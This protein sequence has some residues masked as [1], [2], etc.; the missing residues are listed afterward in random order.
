MDNFNN[1]TVGDSQNSTAQGTNDMNSNTSTQSPAIP[2][3]D[4]ILASLTGM[5]APEVSNAPVGMQE[6][7]VSSSPVLEQVTPTIPTFDTTPVQ[8][9]TPAVEEIPS[10]V[11]D[12]PSFG[13]NTVEPTP[14]IENVP[15]P[16]QESVTPVESTPMDTPVVVDNNMPTQD[17]SSV[18]GASVEVTAPV[19][20]PTVEQ[21]P[22]PESLPSISP[23]EQKAFGLTESSNE[24][25]TD[26][27][28]PSN[29]SQ[30]L[31]SFTPATSAEATLPES[32][33]QEVVS[34]LDEKKDEKD[35][36]GGTAVV[37]VLIIIIVGLLATIGFFAYKIFF[38]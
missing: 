17:S 4:D 7:P 21:S 1:N 33:A 14:V 24:S 11:Q 2:T 25:T 28:S 35:G 37:V 27:S 18:F 19:E 16:V 32:P 23:E 10:L 6:T 26:T 12:L 15:T 29:L 9:S 5:P 38:Q 20:T 34:T 30:P 3:G 22:V 36:K 8:G 13:G 31:P